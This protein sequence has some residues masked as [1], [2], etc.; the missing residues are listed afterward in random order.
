MVSCTRSHG[1]NRQT[2]V[3]SPWEI[4][5]ASFLCSCPQGYLWIFLVPFRLIDPPHLVFIHPSFAGEAEHQQKERV[6]VSYVNKSNAFVITA[7]EKKA[8]FGTQ[9]S[10]IYFNRLGKMQSVV[11]KVRYVLA[12]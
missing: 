8:S 4:V 6:D 5:C 12:C 7:D 10:S 2:Y 11:K 1:A 9:F 3:L